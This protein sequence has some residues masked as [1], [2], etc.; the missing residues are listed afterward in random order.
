MAQNMGGS[1]L[2][3][4]ATAYW[5]SG[6]ILIHA[7]AKTEP[8][9]YIDAEPWLI[10]PSD[11]HPSEI[12][13]AIR[14]ALRAF[15]PSVPVPDY[16]SPEWKALRLGRFRAAGVRSEREF[17]SG[18]KLVDISTVGEAIQFVP[19]RN[20]GSSGAQRGYH[21]LPGAALKAPLKADAESLALKLAEAWTRCT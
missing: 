14:K 12:G 21:F 8:G 15:R 10:L 6:K 20:G 16:R 19:T 9:F 18:S 1:T 17:M 5:R 3:P 13:E 4:C 7:L 11:A 2:G